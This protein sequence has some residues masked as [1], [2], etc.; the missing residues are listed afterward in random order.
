[1]CRV[2]YFRYSKTFAFRF[3]FLFLR[4]QQH[5]YKDIRVSR[6]QSFFVW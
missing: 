2:S 5:S 4:D 6:K 1:M 3:T